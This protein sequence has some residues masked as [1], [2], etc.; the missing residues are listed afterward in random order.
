MFHRLKTALAVAVVGLGAFAGAPAVAQADSLTFTLDRG[1]G[2]VG[3][4]FGDTMP[5][6]VQ[7]R[8]DRD[9]RWRDDDGWDREGDRGW[10]RDD[11]DRGWDRDRRHRRECTP[12]RALDKAERMGLRRARVV[13]VGRRTIDVA[14]RRFGER[15]IVTFGRAP[16]CP[17]WR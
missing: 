5:R 15:V 6:H 16:N 13:D 11:R 8:R 2:R 17:I 3:V 7:N 12:N 14:G 1:D 9:E 10:D 4:E